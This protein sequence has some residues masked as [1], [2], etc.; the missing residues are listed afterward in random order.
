[1]YITASKLY[2]FT[3]CPHRVWRDLYG[4]L[5]EKGEEINPFVQLLWDRGVLYEQQIIAKISQYLDLSRGRVDHRFAETIKAMNNKTPIIYQGVLI[6]DNLMGIPDL[7]RLT[8]AGSYIPI[9]IKSG[10]G[11][12]GTDEN[13]EGKLKEN[14]A[15]QLALYIDA[16]NRLG[17]ENQKQGIILDV[18]GNE[19]LYDLNSIIGKVKNI[20]YWQSYRNIK[21]EV[22]KL[23]SNQI[24]NTPA[25]VGACK[26]CPW[27]ESCKK[28][29]KDNDDLTGLFYVG[30]A[31][32]DVFYS[33]LGTNRIDDVLALDAA[34]LLAKKKKDKDLLKGVGEATLN[35]IFTRAKIFKVSKQ[36]VLYEKIEFPK[37]AY[38]LYFDIEDDPTREFIYLHG[39]YERGPEGERFRDFTAKDI[40]PEV[41]KQAWLEFWKYIRSLP[42][43]DFA[44]YYYSSH[45]K[46]TYRRMQKIYPDVVSEEEVEAFFDHPNTID[47]Y[48]I[49]FKST[50]WPLGSYSIKAI[51]QYLGFSWRDQTPSGALSI[52]WFN[53]YI[54]TKDEKILE[55]ILLYNEDDCKATLVLK[56]KLKELSEKL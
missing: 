13:D 18:K 52:Q 19:V 47:L 23:L 48:K 24:Q 44:V 35:K 9:D 54:E 34:E 7:L 1:M 55:R 38:E 50:D 32:R 6:K 20:S 4:P 25:M 31:K 17:Y 39:V 53:E 43:D 56:D 2:D 51:A 37:V 45:E 33:D 40:T 14:Y 42:K 27:Y 22:E 29:V 12:E 15:V 3:Q 21:E 16:L 30:R 10:M 36:P 11:T 49:V 26:L 41:E 28:W 8:P 5:S 46:S